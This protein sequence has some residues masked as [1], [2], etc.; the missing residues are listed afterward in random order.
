MLT[1]TP[2]DRLALHELIARYAH[3]LDL[4]GTARLGEIYTGD[5]RFIV[6]EFNIDITGL[7]ALIEF[8]TATMAQMSTVRHVITNVFADATGK[9]TADVHSYL[10][11]VDT[12]TKAIT[13]VGVYHDNCI[14]TA[15]G[16]RVAKRIVRTC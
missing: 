5:A 11:T 3:L 15:A 4:G 12:A 14:R 10:H 1:L 6:P 2:D 13:S 8:F 9:D 16:W 7:P